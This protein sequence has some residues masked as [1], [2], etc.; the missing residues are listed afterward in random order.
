M[1][2]QRRFARAPAN[3]A[4][5]VGAFLAEL[6]FQL[7]GYAAYLIPAFL[8]V[9]GWHYFW[10]REIDAAG[11]KTTG[12]VLLFACTS[13]FLSLLLGTV[14]LS[15]KPFRTGGYVGDWLSGEM[16]EYL[17]SHRVGNRHPDADF[18][19]DHPVDAVF[20]RAIFWRAVQGCP[21]RRRP[22]HRC[23]RQMA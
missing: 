23:L 16:A 3:F 1:V 17:E 10:C 4:G 21:Q 20:V 12:G 8:V 18:S 15:G 11:T 5:R 13:A 9:T 6:S 7:V 19:R 2:L 14:T 22:R